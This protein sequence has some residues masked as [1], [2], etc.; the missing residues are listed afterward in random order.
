MAHFFTI[1]CEYKGGT[2]TEQ[3]RAEHPV[4]AFELWAEKFKNE[5]V[6]TQVEKR[7]FVREVQ[8][9]LDQSNL[10]VM[11]GL[12]NIWYE[13][14]SLK[15]DLLEVIIVGMSE[16]PIKIMEGVKAVHMAGGF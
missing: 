6:L 8:Y 13:G 7:K 12:Q 15:D 14:F 3:L 1:I 9:S 4:H 10:A 2:Y 11:N 5:Q 16:Q